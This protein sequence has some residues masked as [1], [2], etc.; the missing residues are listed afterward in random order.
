MPL[1]LRKKLVF[2]LF[3]LLFFVTVLISVVSA[4]EM[5]KNY[6]S[7][8]IQRLKVQLHEIH[9]LLLN[10]NLGLSPTDSNN[11]QMKKFSATTHARLTLTDSTGQVIF[12]SSVPQDSL[13]LLQ[14]HLDRPEIQMAI[15]RGFGTDERM[16]AS[17]PKNMLYAAYRMDTPPT[18]PCFRGL[19]FIRMAMPLTEVNRDIRSMQMKI[20]ISSILALL[21]M[22]GVSHWVSYRF[23]SPISKLMK[24]AESV[25]AG[26]LDVHFEKVSHDEIGELS[27]LLNEMLSKLRDDLVRM[28]KL[29]LVR[30]QFLGNVS[31]ELRT[32]IF[33]VQGYLE[34]LL[35]NPDCDPQTQ[36]SFIS[37]AY[38]QAVR[39]NDL[40]RDLIDISRIE[41]GEMTMSFNS[42]PVHP[43]LNGLVAEL[44]PAA[45]EN[46]ILLRLAGAANEKRIKIT[47]DQER[48]HQVMTNLVM[49]AIKYNRPGGNVEVGYVENE[50]SVTLY[51]KD[52]GRGIPAEH[53]QRIF[54]RFYRVDKERS[55]AMGG[56]GLGL[57]IVKHIVEAHESRIFVESTEGKGSTFRFDLK[58][59]TE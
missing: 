1:S 38:H 26:K 51:V 29:E 4:Y 39:L 24:A 8:I 47:G 23:T 46:G 14:N 9:F 37:K 44:Q 32:P 52:T 40:L 59:T 25:K 45:K 18:S 49:N 34:T 50:K 12:D 43:W 20:I 7:Q 28:R 58:K 6:K 54:E 15:K 11:A 16:S 2:I 5:Q 30:T 19:K 17:I 27:D 31:H 55:R 56:T 35:H 53:L 13:P 33:A 48:L 22:A 36:Q 21:L 42:F 57:A 10:T 41:S 3:S